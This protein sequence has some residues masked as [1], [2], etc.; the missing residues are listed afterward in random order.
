MCS[1]V[2]LLLNRRD[3]SES[4]MNGI[5]LELEKHWRDFIHRNTFKEC[6]AMNENE[7]TSHCANASEWGNSWSTFACGYAI[8]TLK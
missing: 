2:H 1:I 8:K 5:K 7:N 6:N 4:W 3:Y